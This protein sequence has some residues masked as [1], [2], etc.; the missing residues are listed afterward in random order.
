MKVSDLPIA[1]YFAKDVKTIDQL[2]I[3]HIPISG[4]QLMSRAAQAALI[5]L[6]E[7]KKNAKTIAVVC[8]P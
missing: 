4:Y 3:S 2:A 8:D 7:H 6:Q 1:I 5:V